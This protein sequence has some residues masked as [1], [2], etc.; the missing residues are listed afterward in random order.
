MLMEITPSL[1]LQQAITLSV[2]ITR[3]IQITFDPTT[4]D[5]I[6]TD[7]GF[8][9]VMTIGDFVFEDVNEDGVQDFGEVGIEGVSVTLFNAADDSV[10]SST[11]TDFTGQYDFPN[12]PFGNYYLGFDA[13]TNT[14]GLTLTGSPQDAAADDL[15]SDID[16]STN[17]TASFIVDPLTG[18]NLDV[19]AGFFQLSIFSVG[20][21]V[22]QDN[23]GDGIQDQML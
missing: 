5:V 7:A 13:T 18:D 1:E 10:V 8:L 17:E 6:D 15:D 3:P 4:G 12:I 21:F 9:P 11:T 22:W 20:N 14:N 2:L 16:P 23:N 19:D